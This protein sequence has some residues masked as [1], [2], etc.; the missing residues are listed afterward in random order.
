MERDIIDQLYKP[1]AKKQRQAGGGRMFDYTPS[2]DVID[3][4]NKTFMGNWSTEVTRQEIFE[5]QVLVRVSVSAMDPDVGRLFTH[6]GFGSALITR[7]SSGPNEGKVMDIG[8]VFKSASAKAIVNACRRFGVALLDD[9][10]EV[11]KP[12]TSPEQEA[13]SIPEG[14]M[15]RETAPAPT[16]EDMSK[17]EAMKKAEAEMMSNMSNLPPTK[18]FV[19]EP[20]PEPAPE[21][22]NEAPVL[23]KEEKPPAAGPSTGPSLPKSFPAPTTEV[24]PVVRQDSVST[25]APHESVG[26]LVPDEPGTVSDVQ[27]AAIHGFT[28]LKGFVYR[29]L[30][31]NAFETAGISAL[32]IPEP[33]ELS[34]NQ[35]VVIIRRGNKLYRDQ[36]S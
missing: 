31:T 27:M 16:P 8:N 36:M 2:Q 4:M 10:E 17:V 28:E 21:V 26:S 15:G 6:D 14:F 13:P 1:V 12:D 20:V 29:E 22:V 34:Y 3:R 32:I 18:E 24:A 7:F 5:D 33:K 9:E 35:A 30:A 25:P 11:P 19:P 23:P